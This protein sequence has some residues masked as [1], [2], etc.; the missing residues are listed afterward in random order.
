LRFF[1]V[2]AVKFE[3]LI[4]NMADRT[5][6]I[7]RGFSRWQASG[8]HLLISAAIAAVSLF[9]MLRVWYP[10]PLFTTEGGS[11]I[12]LVLIGVDVVIGPLITCIIFRSGKPGLRFDL[13]VIGLLQAA[14]L[15]YGVHVMFVARPVY[16]A[17]M[18]DQFETVRANDLDPADVAQAPR[19]E[20]RSVPVTGPVYVAV[21]LPKDMKMLKELISQA[22]KG[23]ELVQHLPRYYVPYAD[24]KS[25]A[26]AKSRPVETL[27]KD[28][29][30]M[31]ERIERT[32]AGTGR[33]AS[34]LNFMPLQTRRGWG[35]VL[36]DGKTGDVVRI[37]PPV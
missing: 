10:P 6:S 13:S 8:I 14:A 26:V 35:A 22:A 36:I 3:D 34:D 28:D 29:K 16:I 4:S 12:L 5:I 25:K 31:S 1:I 30:A 20:F 21:E 11:D 2:P 37:L 27:R 32:L 7:S 15:I 19:T 18:D 24:Y 33:K 23:G 9:L 17:L